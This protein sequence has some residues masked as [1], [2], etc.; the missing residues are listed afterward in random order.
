MGADM[1][2]LLLVAMM[3]CACAATLAPPPGDSIPVPLVST[4]TPA[5]DVPTDV[6]PGDPTPVP[7]VGTPPV[8][9]PISTVPMC[10]WWTGKYPL[11]CSLSS[12]CVSVPGSPFAGACIPD[13]TGGN[14]FPQ[15]VLPG[16]RVSYFP[17]TDSL[18]SWPWANAS[19]VIVNSK[20][21]E[22]VDPSM[23]DP[24][25]AADER[26]GR[27]LACDGDMQVMLPPIPY[28]R[29][30]SFAVSLWAKRSGAP[31][32]N[33]YEYIYSHS[34]SLDGH[35][36]LGK[37]NKVSIYLLGPPQGRLQGLVRAVVKDST[38]SGSDTFLDS[39][40]AV[41]DSTRSAPLNSSKGAYHSNISD[42]EWHH[43]V[44]TTSPIPGKR[45][46][47]IYV[48]GW[49]VADLP[50]TNNPELAPEALFPTDGGEPIMLTGPIS[51]CG[52]ADLDPSRTF[53]GRVSQLMIFDEALTA[54]DINELWYAQMFP[55]D[56]AADV[57]IPIDLPTFFD[58]ANGLT[59]TLP[60][61]LVLEQPPPGSEDALAIVSLPPGLVL[62]QPP[63]GSKVTSVIA[64]PFSTKS[65]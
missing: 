8:E 61:G 29:S 28:G 17:L 31:T 60:P 4:T 57:S 26:F 41:G 3:A 55:A 11:E 16:R 6:A 9:Q 15:A 21:G 62:E 56:A 42:S 45:G 27:T 47:T 2:S 53:A 65:A 38:D 44:L 19:G 39:D 48:D 52:R 54:N 18:T 64:P 24:Y 49:R 25:W 63:P 43:L 20:T 32:R 46:F 5:V 12:S 10:A 33:L 59:P 40:G 13:P 30:G 50:P 36:E 22:L 51:V 23:W 14:L 58:S 7:L 35:D 37:A 34:E 1:G